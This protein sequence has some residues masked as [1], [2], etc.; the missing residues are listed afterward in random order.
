MAAEADMDINLY[1]CIKDNKLEQIR[2]WE[3]SD[4]NEPNEYLQYACRI[5]GVNLEIIDLLLEKGADINFRNSC[6]VN[7]CFGYCND[8]YHTIVYLIEKGVNIDIVIQLAVEY[9]KLDILRYISLE[10]KDLRQY[11]MEIERMTGDTEISEFIDRIH[12]VRRLKKRRL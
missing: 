5:Q 11:C 6:V 4:S 7:A 8:P 2:S 12:T 10:K 1:K 3:P 9:R